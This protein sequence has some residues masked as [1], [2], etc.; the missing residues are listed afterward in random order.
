MNRTTDVPLTTAPGGDLHDHAR[1]AHEGIGN[2]RK[3][4][5]IVAPARHRGAG[6]NCIDEKG[7]GDLLQP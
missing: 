1:R 5:V 2:G 7:G 3:I 4:E 6:E